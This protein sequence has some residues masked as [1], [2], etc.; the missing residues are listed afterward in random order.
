MEAR[1]QLEIRVSERT[2]ELMKTQA[3]L[4]HLSQVLEHGRAHCFNRS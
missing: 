1:D 2:A 4:A 3:E